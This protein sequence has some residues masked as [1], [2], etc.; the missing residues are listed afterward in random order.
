MEARNLH[1]LRGKTLEELDHFTVPVNQSS[2]S[3]SDECEGIYQFN[4]YI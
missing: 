2:D 1:E 3:E 4:M